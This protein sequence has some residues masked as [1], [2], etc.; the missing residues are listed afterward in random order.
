MRSN[1]AKVTLILLLSPFLLISAQDLP[2]NAASLPI[3][4]LLTLASQALSSGKSNSALTIYDHCLERDP[5]DFATLYKRATLRLATGQWAKAKEGF[6]EVL[7][8]KEFDQAHWQLA[9]L[10]AKVGEFTDALLE[11]DTFLR[12]QSRPESK[13]FIEATELVSYCLPYIIF[14]LDDEII[15]V[16]F[17]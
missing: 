17:F 8:I 11:V 13:E 3:A 12:M 14:N 16:I 15:R 6:A 7:R 10:H 4:H 5:T 2:E 1:L 9:K